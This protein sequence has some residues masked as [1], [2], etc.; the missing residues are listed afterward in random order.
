MVNNFFWGQIYRQQGFLLNLFMMTL[1]NSSLIKYP[2]VH[3]DFFL[4]SEINMTQA[5]V[6]ETIKDWILHLSCFLL[7]GA[8]GSD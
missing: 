7:S 1:L 3:S 8:L 5:P 2:R 4:L 6:S